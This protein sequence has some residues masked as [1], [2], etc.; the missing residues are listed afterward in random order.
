MNQ[1]TTIR[2]KWEILFTRYIVVILKEASLSL[3]CIITEKC[4]K[5]CE[6]LQCAF[7]LYGYMAPFKVRQ[8]VT[9]AGSITPQGMQNFQPF[10]KWWKN[11][12][13]QL[14]MF[15]VYLHVCRPFLDFLVVQ[16][17]LGH[18]GHENSLFNNII[19]LNY[20]DIDQSSSSSFLSN[21][22][23]LLCNWEIANNS[24]YT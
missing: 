17:V 5:I 18:P 1:L 22:G 3:V 15:L 6:L 21:T 8:C 19:Y 12:P 16:W 11:K 14:H 23:F 13:C 7:M 20:F 9:L 2:T 4:Q 10:Q 24:S